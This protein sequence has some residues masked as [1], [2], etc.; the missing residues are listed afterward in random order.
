MVFQKNRVAD[1]PSIGVDA[2]GAGSFLARAASRFDGAVD[3]P[4][5]SDYQ[6]FSSNGYFSNRR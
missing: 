3:V 6:H 5:D 4:A 2:S 1:T